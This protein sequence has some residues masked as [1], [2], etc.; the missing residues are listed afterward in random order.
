MERIING[1]TTAPS[2]AAPPKPVA[3]DKGGKGGK[4][5]PPFGRDAEGSSKL[6]ESADAAMLNFQRASCTLDAS[7]KIWACRVDDV[8]SSSYRVLENLSRGGSGK[9][10]GEGGEGEGEGEG[11]GKGRAARKKAGGGEGAAG[12]SS[13]RTSVTIERNLSSITSKHIE[14]GL[15]IDPLFHAMSAGR[16]GGP[17]EGGAGAT[18]M[19]RLPL[20]AR[21][22][23][24]FDSSSGPAST[25]ATSAWVYDAAAVTAAV[26]GQ[27]GGG[28][29]AARVAGCLS[30]EASA[31]VRATLLGAAPTSLAA[32]FA[33]AAAERAVRLPPDPLSLPAS[34]LLSALFAPTTAVAPSLAA[35]Y[36]SMRSCAALVGDG[37][38]LAALAALPTDGK[39]ALPVAVR[40]PI[41]APAAAP[42]GEDAAAVPTT[43]WAALP[44]LASHAAGGG[45]A[46]TAKPGSDEL[47]LALVTAA[48]RVEATL[49]ALAG[50]G[51]AAAE[52][53]EDDGGGAWGGDDGEQGSPDVEGG[54]AEGGP[55]PTLDAGQPSE[56]A[57][58]LNLAALQSAGGAAG[59]ALGAGGH[60][61]FK[62]AT[63]KAAATA[64]ADTAAAAAAGEAPTAA[65]GVAAPQKRAARGKKAVAKELSFAP[66]AKPPATAFAKGRTLLGAAS[67]G[68]DC[69][70]MSAGAVARAAR[71]SRLAPPGSR[72][73]HPIT[74]RPLGRAD[75]AASMTLV[76]RPVAEL[77]P[78][79]SRAPGTSC[80]AYPL[81]G[82]GGGAVRAA[83]MDVVETDEGDA[84][85][86]GWCGG[87]EYEEGADAAVGGRQEE[88]APGASPAHAAPPAVPGAPPPSLDGEGV[89][90]IA[91]GRVVDR[92]AVRYETVSKR[93]DVHA[94]KEDMGSWLGIGEGGGAGRTAA[95]ALP[96]LTHGAVEAT[97]RASVRAGER[98]FTDVS[99]CG[100][101]AVAKGGPAHPPGA[102]F[103]SSITALAPGLSA[104]VTIPFYFIT[105]L[106]LANEH[107]L[108][109]TQPTG[110]QALNNIDIS[111]LVA[112]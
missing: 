57:S 43:G 63:K 6:L 14:A 91:R 67:K 93:V 70:Q 71:A 27:A 5:P 52:A 37:A 44:V 88:A 83:P 9:E 108:S 29:P 51:A 89:A 56:Y 62:A 55:S 12:P 69:E 21:A 59:S 49:G 15:E 111:R 66:S 2:A 46:V 103:T 31:N 74:L 26:A 61:K 28:P 73:W 76:C 77:A 41:I 81:W 54:G 80:L 79:V 50:A 95:A 64:A 60:W 30:A 84:D 11:E 104:S 90:L 33:W 96:G 13:S 82:V 17:E 87:E 68:R 94:L 19:L 109:L 25:S 100:G 85:G 98:D 42:E 40:P 32:G 75:L 1:D 102:T 112:K 107:G 10:A 48:A 34:A 99:G 22:A 45:A 38:V 24:S 7:I 110:S 86:G 58:G 18:L 23:L 16:D 97:Y 39:G 72:G 4:P 8:W 20:Q 35:L 92:V 106:H 105:L 65:A 36:E 78:A 53:A 101:S 47:P 3:A